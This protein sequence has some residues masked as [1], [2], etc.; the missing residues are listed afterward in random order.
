MTTIIG[1]SGSLRRDSYNSTLLFTMAAMMPNDSQI[2]IQTIQGI[3]LYNGDE[4]SKNGIPKIVSHLKDL[5]A[6]ADGL[7]FVSP[8]YNHGVS[9]VAKN[10]IDWLTR[11]GSDIKRV[12]GGKPIALAGATVGGSGT[13]LAQNSLLPVFHALGANVWA[14]GFFL[15]SQVG[16]L[17]DEKGEINDPETRAGIRHFVEGFV[18]HIKAN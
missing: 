2:Q 16:A 8:E 18:S 6:N 14:G 10:A 15:L 11:P 5:I 13:M 9:G 4:E 12:F 7:L 1:L 17:I 3:P